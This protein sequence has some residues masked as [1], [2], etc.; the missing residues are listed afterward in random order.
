MI[1]GWFKV[2]QAVEKGLP[3]FDKLSMH[4]FFSIIQVMSARP[5][6]VEGLRESFSTA[7]KAGPERSEGSFFTLVTDPSKLRMR[8]A[9]TLNIEL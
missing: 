7:V 6:R 9:R 4:G 5:E 2:Q 1:K 3:C 8:E